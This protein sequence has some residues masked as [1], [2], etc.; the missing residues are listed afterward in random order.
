M[1]DST[2]E[3]HQQENHETQLRVQNYFLGALLVVTF[4]LVYVLFRPYIAALILAAVLV[5]IFFPARQGLTKW[6]RSEIAAAILSTVLVIIVILV[7]LTFFGWIALHEF[8]S[9]VNSGQASEFIHHASFLNRSGV[10]V[11]AYIQ[12]FIGSVFSNIG[13]VLSNL[14]A[15]FAFTGI[16]LITLFFFFKDGPKLRDSLLE[17]LPLSRTRAK[18]L[19]EDMHVGIRAVIGGYVLVA[20]IQ[21]AV[22]GIGYWIFGLHQPALWAAVTV[23]VALIPSFGASIIYI[24]AILTLFSQHHTG[25]AIGLI[26]WAIIALIL[27]D[28][29]VGPRF[30]AERSKINIVLVLF[31]I[32]GGLKIFGPAGFVVG[33]TIIILF[34]SVLGMFQESGI[35]PGSNPVTTERI[36]EIKEGRNV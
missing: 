33:P 30:I 5:I 24:T 23:V 34:W 28:N 29:F 1:I 22:S 8:T 35:L 7:P 21:G 3:E 26:A 18:K 2:P 13:G 27:I 6:V 9:F 12:N 15:V 19:T 32:L 11:Q 36:E 20:V 14:L 17:A 25:S 16:T 4:Y 10:D 31:S